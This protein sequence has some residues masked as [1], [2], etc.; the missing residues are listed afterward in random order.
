MKSDIARALLKN[1]YCPAQMGKPDR[2]RVYE[3]STI[4][5]FV[6]GESGLFFKLVGIEPTLF[7]QASKH[8]G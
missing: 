4:S 6:T 8:L 7:V 3:E 1:L 2:P 5:S